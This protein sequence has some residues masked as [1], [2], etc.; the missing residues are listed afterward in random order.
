MNNSYIEEALKLIQAGFFV[1]PLNGQRPLGF[2]NDPEVV[3]LIWGKFPDANIGLALGPSNNICAL[4]VNPQERGLRSLKELIRLYGSLEETPQVESLMGVRL[5]FFKYCPNFLIP[6]EF[7]RGLKVLKSKIILVPPSTYVSGK[8]YL[9]K[10][11]YELGNI[12]LADIPE[13]L[14]KKSEKIEVNNRGNWLSIY[15][16]PNQRSFVLKSNTV[17]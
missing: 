1:T 9:Y 3:K 6:D 2:T 8:R 14:I 4:R 10:A 17:N 16:R 5:Y 13:F 15:E 12:P 11:G 7:K